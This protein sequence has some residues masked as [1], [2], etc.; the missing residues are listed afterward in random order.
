MIVAPT[1][2]LLIGLLLV[3]AVAFGFM[4]QRDKVVVTLV[5]IYVGLVLVSALTGTVQEFFAGDRAIFNKV[6]I[7]GTDSPFAIQTGIFLLVVM[8]IT[9]RSG[10]SGGSGRGLLSPIELLSYSFF[11]ATLIVA[12][13]LSF[14]PESTKGIILDSS[15][16]ATL[17]NAFYG[18]LLVLPILL[19]IVLGYR[20]KS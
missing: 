5:A 3:L 13:V 2:D 17:L 7:R 1:W 18:W 6:F 15:Q 19:L 4:L 11:N 9:A 20:E 12:S 16:L 10:L 8:A 14:L